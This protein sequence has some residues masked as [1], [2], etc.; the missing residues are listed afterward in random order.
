MD[1]TNKKVIL[2][3]IFNAILLACGILAIIIPCI[4]LSNWYALISVFC[5]SVAAIFPL[6]CNAYAFA[7]MN[8]SDSWLFEDDYEMESGKALSWVLFGGCTTTGFSI[9]FLL[10]RSHQMFLVNMIMCILGGVVMLVA[11]G[12]FVHFIIINK[13]WNIY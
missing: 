12:I 4:I 6:L 9:P 10:W 8:T 5:F 13:K 2:L 1:D 3:I 7:S 11:I